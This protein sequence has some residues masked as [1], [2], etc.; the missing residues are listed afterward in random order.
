MKT[1]PKPIFIGIAVFLSIGFAG[2]WVARSLSR[3]DRMTFDQLST[4][5]RLTAKREAHA[6]EHSDSSAVQH[7]E[8][9]NLSDNG[10]P[11]AQDQMTEE[12]QVMA[13]IAAM[14]TIHFA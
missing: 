7:P 2:G 6:L 9:Q 4:R 3:E 10:Q 1:N 12:E 14:P 8:G 5:Q 13:E 11:Q